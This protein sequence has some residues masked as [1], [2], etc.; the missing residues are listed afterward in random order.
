MYGYRRA[1]L[2][3]RTDFDLF[4]DL[5]RELAR[6]EREDDFERECFFFADLRKVELTSEAVVEVEEVANANLSS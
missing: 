3:I 1:D 5:D 2:W 6:F 4:E